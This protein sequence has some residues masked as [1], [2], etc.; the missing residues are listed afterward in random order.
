MLHLSAFIRECDDGIVAFTFGK[1][2]DE[3][4]SDHL[5]E[6]RSNVDRLE[7]SVRLL[8]PVVHSLASIAVPDPFDYIGFE[9]R[10]IIIPRDYFDGSGLSWMCSWSSGMEFSKHGLSKFSRDVDLAHV[11]PEVFMTFPSFREFVFFSFEVEL[12]NEGVL[13]PFDVNLGSKISFVEGVRDN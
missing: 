6:S 12:E 10:P 13:G 5:P 7:F 3:V 1:T 2:G 9:P 4:S 11:S 8:V